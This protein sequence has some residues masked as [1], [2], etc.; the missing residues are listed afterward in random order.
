MENRSNVLSLESQNNVFLIDWLTVVFHDQTVFGVQHLL[1]L[2]GAD[3]PWQER[4]NFVYGYPVTTFW[5]NISIRWG[6]DNVAFYTDDA[7]KSAAEKVRTDMG[8][9]LEMSGTG[10]RAFEQYGS[11]DWLQLLHQICDCEG[12]VSI[13][14]LDLAYD[15]HTG[16]LDIYRIEQDVRDR[17]YVSKSRKSMITWSDDW[18]EDIQGLTI[19][20]GS[21]KSDVLIR[22]YNKAAERG[23][24]HNKHWVRVELQLRKDRAVVAALEILKGQHVGRTAAGILRNYC[25][26]RTPSSDSNRCR[27]P[28]T[29]Y[30]DKV[31]MDME[32]ISIVIAPGEPYNFHKTEKHMLEQYGQAFICY[33]RMYGETFSFLLDAMKRFPVLKPKYEAAINEYNLMKSERRRRLDEGRKFYGFEVIPEDD[34]FS[35]LDVFEIFGDDLLFDPGDQLPGDPGLGCC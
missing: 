34:P 26:F 9:C 25:T 5:N 12:R 13:T 1:G 31:L 11:G 32:K 7:D 3:I 21:R 35:Q 18:D 24:D 2:T 28:L 30:W 27:W 15:D 4:H 16:L 6:A 14:R 33:Y 23:Y 17:Y 29:D 22:I 20:V 19:E 10:C 8:I